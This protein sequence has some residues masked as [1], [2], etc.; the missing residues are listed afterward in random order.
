MNTMMKRYSLLTLLIAITFP[1]AAQIFN[2]SLRTNNQQLI[3][4]ALSG[5]F[6][7]I[8]QSYELCD[9]IKDEHF[10]RNG[11]DY[12]NIIPFIGINTA[13][14]LVFPSAML[15]PWTYDSEYDEYKE[16]YK[17]ITTASK[18]SVLNTDKVFDIDSSNQPASGTDI[19]KYL[20]LLND[21]IQQRSGLPI[22]TVP[23][24][25]NGWLI[26]LSSNTNLADTDSVRFTSIKKEIEV[27]ID[28]G[29]LHIEKPEISETVYGGVYV[30]PIQTSIGQLMFTL[31]GVLVLG[32]EGWVI[33]F[34]FI[35]Q[36][37]ETK[38][39]TPIND[40]PDRSKLNQL[41]KKKK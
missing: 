29:Y 37:Q 21:T 20:C 13:K 14:G 8:N 18:Y 7:K 33:D 2:F 5:A 16:Q 34:P 24:I 41:K 9:T 28:G 32:E 30:T 25:K 39:L 11:K 38:K 40:F 15:E 31:T 27:P 3:D 23:G 22:D 17:P 1:M 12:F 10:G 19:T 35:Q 4:E 6:I 26:W 36:P